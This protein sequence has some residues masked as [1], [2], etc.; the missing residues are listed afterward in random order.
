MDHLDG[1]KAFVEESRPSN[2]W[3]TANT[4]EIEEFQ[5]RKYDEDDWE[6]YVRL[7]ERNPQTDPKRLVL[8]SGAEGAYHNPTEKGE[9]CGD[10]F[11]IFAPARELVA[12]ANEHEEWN[13][14]SYVILYGTGTKRTPFSAD[15]HDRT[16]VHPRPLA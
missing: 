9:G 1:M 8:Y 6:F 14:S 5:K 13:D 15:S 3:D 4:K 12:D 7:R 10:E 11:Y 16:R 2:F